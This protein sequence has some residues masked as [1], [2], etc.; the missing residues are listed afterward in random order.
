MTSQSKIEPMPPTPGRGDA[1]PGDTA[2]A[3]ANAETAAP[4]SSETS[5]VAQGVATGPDDMA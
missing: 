1:T 2:A 4:G 5:P 3:P